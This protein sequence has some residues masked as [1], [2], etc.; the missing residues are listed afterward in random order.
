MCRCAGIMAGLPAFL[1]T[2]TRLAG[3]SLW[4]GHLGLRP[5]PRPFL[6]RR[7]LSPRALPPRAAVAASTSASSSRRAATAATP[8][9][10]AAA[11]TSGG[12]AALPGTI[13]L[14]ATPIGNMADITARALSI[15]DTVDVVAAEDTRRTGLLLAR[16]FPSNSTSGVGGDRR[17]RGQRLLSYHAHNTHARTPHLLSL[18]Q[19]GASVAVV[20]DAGTPGVSDPGSELVAAAVR[21]C[22]PVVPVPGACAAVAALIA[23]G[24]DT[25]SWTFVGFL[26]TRRSERAKELGRLASL[27]STLVLYEAPHRVAASLAA[28]ADVPSLRDRQVAVARELTKVHEEFRLFAG[29]G[30]AAEHYCAGGP[31]VLKGEFVLVLGPPAKDPPSGKGT[32]VSIEERQARVM[33]EVLISEGVPVSVAARGVAAATGVSR[34]ALY[35]HAVQVVKDTGG[36]AATNG[37]SNEVEDADREHS[38]DV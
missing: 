33:I 26:P 1:P 12:N 17:R 20:S 14:V 22:V 34:R 16:L 21:A 15:L 5:P 7:G 28:I 31:G 19:G 18:A 32:V 38:V 4:W 25:S 35:A 6:A 30:A 10:A 9:A 13:Y 3:R 37:V 2:A 24:L 27:T 8:A 36:G 23:S 11:D 29:A